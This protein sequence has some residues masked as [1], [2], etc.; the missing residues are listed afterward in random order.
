MKIALTVLR[1]PVSHIPREVATRALFSKKLSGKSRRLFTRAR[2]QVVDVE[3]K[4]PKSEQEAFCQKLKRLTLLQLGNRADQAR[5]GI[6]KLSKVLEDT[7]L[8]TFRKPIEQA[9]GLL[10]YRAGWIAQEV[11]DRTFNPE[12]IDEKGN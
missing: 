9:L 10:K 6:R 1:K 3:R 12:R 5:R 2:F 7:E 4:E 8:D 11:Q